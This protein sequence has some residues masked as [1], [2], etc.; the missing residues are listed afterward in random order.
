MSDK[1][2]DDWRLD[3][4]HYRATLKRKVQG[5]MRKAQRTSISEAVKAREEA[6]EKGH[7]RRVIDSILGKRGEYC[8][9]AKVMREDGK[10]ETDPRAVAETLA[11]HFQEA[12]AGGGTCP[13]FEEDGI[14][15]T[16]KKFFADSWKVGRPGS[17]LC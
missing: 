11:N 10:V 8:R 6:F 15:P 7:F 3:L 9:V 13:W 17:R 5:R 2:Y 1:A 12:F 14:P 16:V 4:V